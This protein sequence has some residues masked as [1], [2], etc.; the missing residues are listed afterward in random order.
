MATKKK[1]AST[2]APE[3]KKEDLKVFPYKRELTVALTTTEVADRA[4]RMSHKLAERDIKEQVIKEETKRQKTVLKDMETEVRRLSNSVRD[5]AELRTVQ[6][7]RRCNYS[8]GRVQDVRIDTGEV[9]S[10]RDMTEDERQK[11]LP[12]DD[13]DASFDDEAADESDAEAAE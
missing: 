8:T 3:K 12:F 2:D 6:C 1:K 13:L 11:D 7:E 4:K 10:E 5:G 9:L